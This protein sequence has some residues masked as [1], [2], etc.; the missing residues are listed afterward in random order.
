[1]PPNHSP[2]P[3]P[4]DA[5]HIALGAWGEQLAAQHL[6]TAGM[7]VLARNWRSPAG[8]VDLVLRD[9]ADLVLCEVKTR[10]SLTAGFPHEAVDQRRVARVRRAGLDWLREHA[11]RP[12]DVRVD[13]VAV[14]APRHG[15]VSVE[16]VR[17][18]G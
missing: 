9:G 6:V 3:S 11:A 1:M 14:L 2:A 13:L 5:P 8:E 4:H 17:G 15:A 10:T 7:V 12:R 18:I 16:H